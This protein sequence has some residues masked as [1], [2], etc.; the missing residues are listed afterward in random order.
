MTIVNKLGSRVLM[1]TTPDRRDCPLSDSRTGLSG[2]F[3]FGILICAC[4]EV[5]ALQAA[6]PSIDVQPIVTDRPD[7]TESTSVVGSKVFQI[8]MGYTFTSDREGQERLTD[9]TAPEL[10]LRIGIHDKV[11]LRLGWEGFSATEFNERVRNDVGRTID[12]Q[13]HSDGATDL[14]LGFK[15]HML[16]QDGLN[17]DFGVIVALSVPTGSR[18]KTS[19]DVVP[20]VKWLWA[21]DLSDRWSL[22]GNINF[23][24]PTSEE[25]RFFQTASSISLAYGVND[26]LGAYVEYFGFYP[27]DR[28]TD[29][30]HYANG[31]LTFGINPDLQFDIRAGWGLNEEADDFFAGVGMAYRVPFGEIK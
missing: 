1:N 25:G 2:S 31:G 22:A 29:C 26:W 30:A 13:S 15:V 24:V 9:H 5:V 16:D 28:G 8:E 6:D 12:Q 11:E 17:P 14:S 7:F 18:D 27:A 19:G 21:Y 3:M 10:L 23:A 20:E 4:S